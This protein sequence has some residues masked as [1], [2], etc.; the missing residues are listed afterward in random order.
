MNKLKKSI[1]FLLIF[2]LLFCTLSREVIL[3]NANNEYNDNTINPTVV[4]TATSLPTM[5]LSDGEII[6]TNGYYSKNDGGAQEYKISREK[7]DF[8]VKLDNGLYANPIFEDNTINLLCVGAKAD[9][10]TDNSTIINKAFNS[11]VENIYFP[12]GT[13]LCDYRLE[14][15]NGNNINIYGDSN[16]S[17]ITTDSDYIGASSPNENFI[18]LWEC[19]DISFKDITIKATEKWTVNYQRQLSVYYSENISIEKCSFI[20]PETVKENG[21][22]TDREYTNLALYTGWKNVSVKDCYFEQLGAVERGCN[23]IITDIWNAGCENL[24]IQNNIFYHN[25]HDEMF[26]LFGGTGDSSYIRNVSVTDNEFNALYSDE[27][28]GRTMCFTFGYLDSKNVSDV[29]F[30]NNAINATTPYSLMTFG[31][32]ENC[33]VSNN[34]ITITN[35]SYYNNGIGFLG[36]SGVT[37]HNNNITINGINKDGMA[38]LASGDLYFK[39]NDVI[40]NTSMRYVFTEGNITGNTITLNGHVE[41]IAQAPKFME[42]NHFEINGPS[43]NFI[44]YVQVNLKYSST[45]IN[46][47]FN[48]NYNDTSASFFTGNAIYV[49]IGTTLNNNIILFSYNTINAPNVNTFRKNLLSYCVL[50]SS[51]QTFVIR[52]NTSDTFKGFVYL[53]QGK[54]CNILT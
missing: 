17:I 2:S 37:V 34:D 24:N 19:N 10:S 29:F 18:T 42:N 25:A 21:P 45:V 36:T 4:A 30:Q 3:V 35:N 54:Q 48:Y 26:S 50:D 49:N 27:V 39:D 31:N 44:S 33:D 15:T 51:A 5:N 28:S 40:I 46:N 6:K 32:I 12:A 13:Y 7:K 43:D 8:S 41:S 16:K 23:I 22:N 52:N 1:S 14:I 20:I 11:G 38:T 53:C 9:G 47:T